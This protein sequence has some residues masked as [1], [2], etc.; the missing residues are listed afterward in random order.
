MRKK[1]EKKQKKKKGKRKERKCGG[2]LTRLLGQGP[3]NYV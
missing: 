1:K 3:A 2:D